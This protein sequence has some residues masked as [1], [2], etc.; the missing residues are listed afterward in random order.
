MAWSYER[1]T[2]RF[3]STWGRAVFD[4]GGSPRRLVVNVSRSR[5][6]TAPTVVLL[7]TALLLAACGRSVASGELQGDVVDP[8]RPKPSF[9]LTD[10][11]GERYEFAAETQGKLALLYFGY[12]NCPD[13]CPVHLAQ[14]AEVFDQLSE[15][16]R[17]T[18]VVFVSVDPDR[19]SPDEI[20]AFLDNIDSRFIGLTGTRAELDTA[21]NEAGVPPAI[22]EGDGD[23]YTV[24][25]AGW[26]IAYAPDGLEHANYPFGTRQSTW[27]NDLQVLA[28]REGGSG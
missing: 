23:D 24:D 12:V 15:V 3:A 6:R 18:E 16:A 28:A 27:A 20:R 8:P 9:T 1:E 13:I 25:H 17:E 21:Q 19:D 4:S 7:V 11:S 22:I 26:V 10:T 5:L 2:E 14:I